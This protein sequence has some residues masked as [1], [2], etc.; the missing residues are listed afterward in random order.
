MREILV[1]CPQERDRRAIG[2]ARLETHFAVR[3]AGRDLDGVDEFDPAAF[4]AECERLPADGV[5]ATKDQSALLAAI[6]AERRGLPGP[7]PHALL[8]CQHKPTSRELQRK[9]APDATPR[10]ALLDGGLP[11]SPPFFVKPVVGRL[12]QNVMQIDD[13]EDLA[14]LPEP[15]GYARRY[16][17]IAAL[18]GAPPERAQGFLA[19]ELLHGL[20]VTLEG[21][22]HRGRVTTIGVTDSVM[23]PGTISFERFEYPSR[24]SDERQAELAEIA[25]AVVRAHELDDAFFNLEFFV[26]EDGCPGIVE[27]NA[28]LASQF[29][30]LVLGL[31]GRSTYD[32]LFALSAGEDPAWH[33]GRPDG[34]GVS[35]VVRVF[36]DAHV[37]RVPD[38]ADDIEIL[39][40]P[41]LRLS[42]QGVNDAQSYRLAILYGFG[43][44]R[45]EAVR[46]CRERVRS[47]S[48]RLERSP[49]AH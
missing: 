24:L 11:F 37:E 36:E 27:L 30:P 46:R 16:G 15:D 1:L 35:Y 26:P 48:F 34:V 44:T 25:A 3:Y 7:S 8:A 18:A 13:E 39:V 49:V 19:E 21:Y 29:A 45:E 40:R 28:R 41:G 12:S 5:V 23:Y 32:A 31:H 22:V 43:E 42:E 33:S 10:A 6:L 17:A 2:A 4:L 38:A 9:V 47:L 20:E 14:A